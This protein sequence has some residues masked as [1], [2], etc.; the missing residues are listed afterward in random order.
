VDLG[1]AAR[2]PRRLRI[3]MT[4]FDLWEGSLSELATIRRYPYFS[5]RRVRSIAEDNPIDLQRHWLFGIQLPAFLGFIPQIGITEQDRAVRRNQMA[6]KLEESIGQLA[7]EDFVTPPSASFVKGCGPVTIAAYTRWWPRTK[8]ERKGII[9][10]TRT[11]SSTGK[12]VE[13]CLFGSVDNCGDYLSGSGIEAPTWSSSSTWAIEEFI[14]N[15]GA[16]PAPIY[17]DDES[18]AV[19]IVRVFNNEGMN[20]RYA[21]RRLGNA[22][23]F[24]EVYHDVELDEQRWHQRIAGDWP[25]YVDRIVIGAPLWVR[26]IS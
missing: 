6:E 14:A 11:T 8:S 17:D 3:L 21:F 4:R 15:K 20:D 13:I 23:W 18:I 5:E 2:A 26:T 9:I 22:E 24:G 12:R 19:E 25:Q 1:D 10:H 7:V 16:T